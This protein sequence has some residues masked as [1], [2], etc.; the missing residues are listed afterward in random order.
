MGRVKPGTP[1][2]AGCAAATSAAAAVRG[3]LGASATRSAKLA[4]C[5]ARSSTAEAGLK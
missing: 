4:L 3:P 2:S 1:R 5:P